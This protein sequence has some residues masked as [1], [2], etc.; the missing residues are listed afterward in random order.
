M[1]LICLI[2]SILQGCIGTFLI[3]INDINSNLQP[4][5]S[6]QLSYGYFVRLG[7]KD[8]G[9]SYHFSSAHSFNSEFHGM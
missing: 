1:N 5:A 6:N 7:N 8:S 3:C 2:W 4:S 9:I